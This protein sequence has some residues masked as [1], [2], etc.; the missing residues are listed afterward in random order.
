MKLY[1][2]RKVKLFCPKFDQNLFKGQD[3]MK[4]NKVK[5]RLHTLLELKTVDPRGVHKLSKL[6]TNVDGMVLWCSL[7]KTAPGIPDR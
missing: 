1:S 6:Q 4:M 3:K 2:K 7:I 5:T